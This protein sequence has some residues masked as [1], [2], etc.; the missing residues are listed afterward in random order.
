MNK[1]EVGKIDIT[2]NEN[3]V[4]YRND[5]AIINIENVSGDVLVDVSVLNN[6]GA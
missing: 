5:T 4:T 6:S 2:S 3:V 1:V